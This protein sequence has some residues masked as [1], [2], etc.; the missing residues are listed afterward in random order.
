MADSPTTAKT[1]AIPVQ[2]W[3]AAIELLMSEL[4]MK[5]CEHVVNALRQATPLG[6]MIE[7]PDEEGPSEQGD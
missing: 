3:H 2:V 6:G 5:K 4:P 1:V 7:K